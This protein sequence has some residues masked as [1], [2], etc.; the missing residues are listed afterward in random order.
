MTFIETSSQVSVLFILLLIGFILKKTN[1]ITDELGKGL[2]GLIIYAT[3]PAL[4]ITSMNYKFSKDMLSNSIKLFIIG[5]F[6]YLGL[7]IISIIFTKIY[8]TPKKQSGVYKVLIIFANV[9]FMGYPVVELVYGKIGV[10]YAAFFNLWFNILLW[11]LAIFLLNSNSKISLKSLINPGTISILLGFFLFIFSI[12]LP[13][14]IYTS[15]NKLG[16][17]TTPMS[18]LVVGSMLG[19]AKIKEI[20]LNKKLIAISIIRLIIVPMLVLFSLSLFNLN[21]IVIGIPAIIMG[22]PSAA[23]AAIFSRRFDSDYRLASQG[24]F[25]TTLLS[26]ISIPFVIYI[27]T[28]VL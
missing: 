20:F 4:V 9:G 23:N 5:F 21:E 26:I 14:P 7:I 10:F 6:I 2:S 13:G 24:V 1:I 11:T 3:L 22:M 18:M 19:D 17:S 16:A 15:L 28:G 8:K 27:I 12:K 25:L